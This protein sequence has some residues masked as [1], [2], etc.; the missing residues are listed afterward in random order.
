MVLSICFILSVECV[1]CGDDRDTDREKRRDREGGEMKIRE[2]KST[3]HINA[4]S[5][6]ADLMVIPAVLL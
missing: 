2:Q 1:R 5:S 3:H 4:H 6:R